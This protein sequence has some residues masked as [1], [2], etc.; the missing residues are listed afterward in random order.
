MRE[1]TI[2]W[3]PGTIQPGVVSEM[4]STLDLL[5]TFG[6]LAGADVPDDRILDG[7]DLTPVLNGTG[8]SPRRQMVYY[9]GSEIYAMR[10]GAYKAHFITRP[11][12]GRDG[13]KSHDPPLLYNLEVDPSEKR[14]VAAKHPEVIADIKAAVA[15][16]R[17]TVTPVVNQLER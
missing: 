10:L 17:E 11:A 15:A 6:A 4:G 5:P 7:D 13:P 16:H 1:P 3:W 14:N 2:F 8:P 9:R 12:Y